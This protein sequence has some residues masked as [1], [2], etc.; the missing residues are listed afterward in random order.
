MNFASARLTQ[1]VEAEAFRIYLADTL[2]FLAEGKQINVRWNE[3]LHPTPIVEH[4]PDEVIE[5]IKAGLR[6]LMP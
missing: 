6:G 2:F 1:R 4:D 5:N 3:F